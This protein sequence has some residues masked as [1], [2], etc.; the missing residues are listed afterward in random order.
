MNGYQRFLADPKADWENRL[1]DTEGPMSKLRETLAK[2]KP[3]PA[4]VALAE[5][6]KLNILKCVITQNIDN[7]HRAAGSRNVAEIHGN[8]QLL[9]CLSCGARYPKEKISLETL[10][11]HCP[12]CHGIIKSDSV[13]FG[14]PIPADVLRTCQQETDLSDCMLVVGT[15]ALVYPAAHFPQEIKGKGGALIEINLYET[16]LT[17]ICNFSFRGKAGE[18][19][20]Q[21]LERVRTQLGAKQN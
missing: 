13:M 12:A 17:L 10:P 6:E 3:N 8:L 21:L 1:S 20:P 9:R 7:L 4:H 15:S 14:E 18:V 19:M 11:P 5:L 16:A 2:A